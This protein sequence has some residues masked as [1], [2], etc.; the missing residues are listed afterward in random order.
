MNR[1]VVMMMI[2]LLVAVLAVPLTLHELDLRQVRESTF[3]AVR[4]AAIADPAHL[5]QL[6]VS[7]WEEVDGVAAPSVRHRAWG[8]YEMRIPRVTSTVVAEVDLRP[9][10]AALLLGGGGWLRVACCLTVGGAVL[11]LGMRRQTP[12]MKKNPNALALTTTVRQGLRCTQVPL[13]LFRE[14]LNRLAQPGVVL[15]PDYRLVVW[16]AAIQKE[17]P[18]AAWSADLHLLD[19]AEILPW[20]KELLE[21]VDDYALRAA[22]DE[23]ALLLIVKE[24]GRLC[25][26]AG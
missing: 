7:H 4:F 1:R 9:I 22:A 6:P 15:D 19:L 25:V 8:Q 16:N 11:Y 23:A 2:A 13:S 21:A 18:D 14:G 10:F 3:S 12:G 17:A 24:G 5:S 20:G 26:V